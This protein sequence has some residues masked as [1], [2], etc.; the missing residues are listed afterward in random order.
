[1]TTRAQAESNQNNAKKST[2]PK[3]AE[4][5]KRSSL[6]SLV[7]GLR[8]EE[9][10][11][12]GEDPA[13]FEAERAAWFEDFQ[14]KSQ[15]R[16]A[17]VERAAIAA[18]RCR[19]CVRIEA[20]R[21]KNLGRDAVDRHEAEVAKQVDAAVK[22][23]QKEPKRALA[24]LEGE[25]EGRVRLIQ[26]WARLID[27]ASTDRS[28]GRSI[29]THDLLVNL[30]GFTEDDDIEDVGSAAVSSLRLLVRVNPEIDANSNPFGPLDALESARLF[31]NLQLFLKERHNE[32]QASL[33]WFTDSDEFRNQIAT[34]AFIDVSDEGKL[35]LRYEATHDR[36]LR[37]T[38]SSLIQL[39]KSGAD[40]MAAEPE[41]AAEAIAPSEPIGPKPLEDKALPR[42]IGKV[43]GT[44]SLRLAVVTPPQAVAA[45]LPQ[46]D[47]DRGG[48][49]WEEDDIFSSLKEI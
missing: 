43:V 22:I 35:L 24:I 7:H 11:L 8:S 37:A 1:M 27:S 31:R 25:Y 29:N 46:S 13:A 3:S 2:G 44:G 34:S 10:V 33:S 48:R 40:L 39:E 17:L 45:P 42:E 5:K 30:L 4:G 6:N 38:I 15:A 36:S 23:L 32:L 26:L 20:V 19:R 12:P 14:P 41:P 21:L 49:S 18:W 28:W 47:R 16:A 9:V